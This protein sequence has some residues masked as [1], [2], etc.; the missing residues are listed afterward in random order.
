MLNSDSVLGLNPTKQGSWGGHSNKHSCNHARSTRIMRKGGVAMD[1]SVYY[2]NVN[3]GQSLKIS[4]SAVK[5]RKR[6]V[7]VL[8]HGRSC[9]CRICG[10]DLPLTGLGCSVKGGAP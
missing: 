10:R 2:R 1:S 7:E 9:D 6:A 8:T 3:N 5:P 4:R